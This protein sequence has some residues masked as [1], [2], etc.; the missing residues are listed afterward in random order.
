[1]CSTL[2]LCLSSKFV[3]TCLLLHRLPLHVACRIG[4]SP[5][6][7]SELLKAYPDGITERTMKGSTPLMC[8]HKHEGAAVGRE[9]KVASECVVEM[10]EHAMKAKGMDVTDNGETAAGGGA[11]GSQ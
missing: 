7:I 5:E 9:D 3:P 1:M 11:D 4:E 2:F 10:L 6:V 8:A